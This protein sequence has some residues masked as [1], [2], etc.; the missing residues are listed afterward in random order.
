MGPSYYSE[1]DDPWLTSQV[2]RWGGALVRYTATYTGSL[3]LA[4]DATQEA[5][6]RLLEWRA[7]HPLAELQP[8]WLF[9]VAQHAAVDLLRRRR[10]DK[11]SIPETDSSPNDA[12]IARID[13]QRI[14]KRMSPGDRE[15]LLLFYF[16]DMS[17]TDIADQ[18]GVSI[19]TVKMRLNRA[20]KRFER[21]WRG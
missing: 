12:I 3:D 16:A 15:C 8:A 14:L 2:E 7:R 11:W 17:I 13:V 4:Q 20:R 9:T 18:I 6:L 1:M 21:Y 5:F 10:A 19:S